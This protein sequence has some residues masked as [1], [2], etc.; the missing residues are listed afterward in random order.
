MRTAL[1]E[2]GHKQ[3][4][5]GTPFDT[6]NKTA[7]GILTRT[8]RQKLSKAFD[9]RYWWMK[10]RIKQKQFDL[11][12]SPGKGNL[13]D[14]FTKHHPPWHHKKMRYRYLQKQTAN[15]ALAA[16]SHVSCTRRGC[17][18]SSGPTVPHRSTTPRT[19]RAHPV[20]DLPYDR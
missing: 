13:A 4:A 7:R 10:D 16:Q 2:L 11:M 14:Y 19:F 12:W 15:S 9:M 3:P 5:T 18:T 1:E 20:M 6:D 8:M 17:V